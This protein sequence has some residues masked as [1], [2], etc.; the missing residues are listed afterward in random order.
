MVQS[1][2][3][4]GHMC[5]W[6]HVFFLGHNRRDKRQWKQLCSFISIPW[7]L[8]EPPWGPAERCCWCCCCCWWWCW[9]WRRW[10][11]PWWPAPP[12]D[13]APIKPTPAPPLFLTKSN[14]LI[15]SFFSWIASV[16]ANFLSAEKKLIIPEI[17]VKN[18]ANIFSATVV[19]IQ[20]AGENNYN[21]RGLSNISKVDLKTSKMFVC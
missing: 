18:M 6:L 1:V 15:W 21:Y 14:T 2:F 20:T 10:S 16:F 7:T 4:Q 17:S 5:F 19:C 13:P 12:S 11:R 9:W 8:L 3:S